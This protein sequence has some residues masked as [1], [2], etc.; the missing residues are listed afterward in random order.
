[1]IFDARELPLPA[2]LEA[3]VC[4]VGSGA[5]GLMAA[6]V[7]AEA[8]QRVVLLEAGEYLTPLDMTQREEEMFPRLLWDSGGRTTDDRAVKVHQ[9][10]GVGGSTLHNLSLCKRI[11][12]AVRDA[13]HRDAGLAHL[14]PATWD[15][16]YDEVERLLAVGE[17]PEAMRSRHNRLLQA[18][19]E[20]LGWRSGPLKYNRTGCIGAGFCEL[21]CSYDAKNHAA[22]VL[23]PRAVKAGA[24]VLTC[25]HA[26]RVELVRGQARAVEA[27][28]VEPHG[29]KP[30]GRVRVEAKR[31]CLAASA[32]ATAALLLRSDVPDPSGL[33]GNTLRVHPGVV[34]AGEFDAPVRAWEGV[35]QSYECTELLRLDEPGGNRVWLL[36]AFAHPVGTATM[37]PGHGAAHRQWMERYPYLGVFSAMIHDETA[38]RVRPRGELGLSLDYWPN[39]G[40][41]QQLSLGLWGCAKLL[42]AAGARRIFV[43]THAA[44]WVFERGDDLASLKD[45][46]LRAGALDLVAVHPMSSVPMGDDPQR[47]VV[48]SQGR[49]HRVDNLFVAD[50]SLFPTSIGVPPQL[51][52]YALG[53]HVGRALARQ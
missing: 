6:M 23:L 18:G 37:L 15:A 42:F 12:E 11:P 39:A 1:M 41:R 49:H 43:P 52:I 51:S 30:L 17:I 21:G 44:P 29:R 46:E 4:V 26:V 3:D 27:L 31:I 8:G 38:G 19:A 13:W 33:T 45:Y 47:S 34:A 24:E 10:H 36:P 40:D 5:G 25:C 20:A 48:D 9:G 32:T 2:T 14:P 22:K 28:A 16:L 50:G 7:A 35:P 53:L